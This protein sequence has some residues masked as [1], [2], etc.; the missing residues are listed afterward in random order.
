MFHTAR[1]NQFFKLLRDA[2]L[3][4]KRC[5]FFSS[6]RFLLFRSFLTSFRTHNNFNH[7][8]K[9]IP[10]ENLERNYKIK[11]NSRQSITQLTVVSPN[12]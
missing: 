8:P 4:V 12:N 5:F 9:L 2:S 11:T 6:L 10:D 7:H 1:Y 3:P